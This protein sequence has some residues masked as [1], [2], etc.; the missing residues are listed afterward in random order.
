MSIKENELADRPS[1]GHPRQ[2]LR[3]PL[4]TTETAHPHGLSKQSGAPESPLFS[5]ASGALCP[6]TPKIIAKYPGGPTVTL[7]RIGGFSE[8]EWGHS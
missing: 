6:W 1:D 5:L 3:C 4:S 8:L 7:E 2:P